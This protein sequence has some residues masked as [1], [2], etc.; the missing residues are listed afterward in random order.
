MF[1]ERGDFQ[2]FH[3]RAEANINTGGNSGIYFRSE[4]G[5]NGLGKKYPAGYEAQIYVGGPNNAQR[6]GSLHGFAPIYEDLVEPNTWFSLEVI[7]RGK[8]TVIKVNDQ[9]V[10]DYVDPKST[11][12]RGHFALQQ[13]HDPNTVVQFR[14]I[15]VK[16]L[17]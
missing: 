17:K 15:E 7:A 14:K 9:T 6:T 3:L 16:L 1:S 12:T 8:H 11:Y 13:Q 2:D 4:F 10:V 5:L